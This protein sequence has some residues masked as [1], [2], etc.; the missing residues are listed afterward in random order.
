MD[1]ENVVWKYNRIFFIHKEQSPIICQKIGT[2]GNIVLSK[3]N[4]A[5]GDKYYVFSHMV[6]RFYVG[7]LNHVLISHETVWGSKED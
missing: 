3:S 4:Q 6:P 2:T 1:N 7:A 5:Q